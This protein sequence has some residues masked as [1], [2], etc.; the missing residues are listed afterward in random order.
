MGAGLS[1]ASGQGLQL[2]NELRADGTQVPNKEYV[3]RLHTTNSGAVCSGSSGGT[4]SNPTVTLAN[5]NGLG[6]DI[7]PGSSF[8]Y[9]RGVASG[10]HDVDQ[11]VFK[12]NEIIAVSFELV[13]YPGSNKPFYVVPVCGSLSPANPTIIK[14]F[15]VPGFGGFTFVTFE[16]RLLYIPAGPNSPGYQLF[17]KPLN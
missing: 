5:P 8:L 4:F 16:I 10:V 15:A 12:N 14:S 7:P 1:S 13:S 3:V 17:V 9:E 6:Y 2:V 11:V